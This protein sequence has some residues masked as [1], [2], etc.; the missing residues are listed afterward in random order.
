M[1]LPPIITDE[2]I[3]GPSPSESSREFE[4]NYKI[5]PLIITYEII[6]GLSPLESS[7]DLKKIIGY[8]GSLNQACYI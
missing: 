7:R 1:T 8:L 4:K 5:F 2:I 6:D 3:Y